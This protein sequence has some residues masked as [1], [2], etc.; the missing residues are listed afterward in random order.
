MA[1]LP[2]QTTYPEHQAKSFKVSHGVAL[3]VSIAEEQLLVP[4]LQ[5]SI[6]QPSSC[7]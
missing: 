3:G 7:L 5:N 6:G 1:S 4:P 2:S